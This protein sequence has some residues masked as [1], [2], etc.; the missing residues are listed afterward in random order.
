MSSPGKS[1]AGGARA[2]GARTSALGNR[3]NDCY[4]LR[5]FR[6]PHNLHATECECVYVFTSTTTARPGSLFNQ[7]LSLPQVYTSRH[8]H[9]HTIPARARMAT[10]TRG[11]LPSA[12]YPFLSFAALQLLDQTRKKAT[13]GC[14]RGART[15]TSSIDTYTLSHLTLAGN[16][17]RVVGLC[18]FILE[19]I[20]LTLKSGKQDYYWHYWWRRR[21]PPLLLLL[22]PPRH[23]DLRSVARAR[24]TRRRERLVLCRCARQC[25][26]MYI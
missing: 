8:T 24:C 19:A 21:R 5:A 18:F 3:G 20:G 14:C 23:F 9:T 16:R 17:A 4:R 7:S 13:L 15:S 25:I 11:R 22:I 6:R 12:Y 1:F 2:V 26:Y 10:R